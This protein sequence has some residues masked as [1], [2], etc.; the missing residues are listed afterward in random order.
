MVITCSN[1]RIKL[2]FQ[3]ENIIRVHAAPKSKKFAVDDLY[4]TNNGPYHILSYDPLSNVSIFVV[5]KKNY[6]IVKGGQLKVRVSKSPC[7]FNFF[8]PDGKLLLQEPAVGGIDYQWDKE[9]FELSGKPG[10]FRTRFERMDDE[11]FFGLGGLAGGERCIN[12]PLDKT[13]ISSDLKAGEGRFESPF[14]Y[15]TRGYGLFFANIGPTVS[16]SL[17]Q[18]CELVGTYDGSAGKD[19]DY[20]V[21]YGPSFERILHGYVELTGKPLLPEKWFFG[22]LMSNYAWGSPAAIR[23]AATRFREGDWPLDAL[24]ED[25]AWRGVM[26]P[27]NMRP[28]MSISCCGIWIISESGSGF[29]SMVQTSLMLQIQKRFSKVGP[30]MTRLPDRE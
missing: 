18:L 4:V 2:S 6:W 20:Y 5:E 10:L 22:L 13:G 15:S 16:V 11:H 8:G 12:R 24:I 7:R 19:L 27:G 1:G 30:N 3:A 14:Y 17:K 25:Y 26:S 23:D 28:R 29:M 21:I 9:A